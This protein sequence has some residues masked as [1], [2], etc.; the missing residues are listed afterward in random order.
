M[1]QLILSLASSF[2]FSRTALAGISRLIFVTTAT[3]VE[4]KTKFWPYLGYL[5]ANLRTFFGALL[6]GLNSAAAHK[7]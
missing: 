6:A 3:T 5:V 7:N 2:P 1:V 4:E